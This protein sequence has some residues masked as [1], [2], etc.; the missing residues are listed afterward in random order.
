MIPLTKFER[1]R[2]HQLAEEQRPALEAAVDPDRCARGLH[3]PDPGGYC[4]G[5]RHELVIEDYL[6]LTK[7][8]EMDTVNDPYAP[9]TVHDAQSTH[10]KRPKFFGKVEILTPDES[11]VYLRRWY[12]MRFPKLFSLRLHHILL[13]DTDRHPHDH[14]W[15]FVSIILRGGY[16]EVWSEGADEFRRTYKH[17][18]SWSTAK[19][20]KTVRRISHHNS[21]DLHQIVR[22]HRGST[23]SL[24]I[25]GPEK[26]V[27]GFQT[28][29]GWMDWKRYEKE[30]LGIDRG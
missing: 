15:P 26:R 30:V 29:D 23:W 6:A 11:Q 17:L 8:H 18:W 9:P 12:L 14:P 16:D 24:F 3:E 22:F 4:H 13:P 19:V 25:T 28:E 2:L 20:R 21:T 1:R 27:W 7:E 5:C 10:Y